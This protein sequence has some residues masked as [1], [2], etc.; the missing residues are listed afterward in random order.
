MQPSAEPM[1]RVLLASSSPSLL[2]RNQNL[3]KRRGVQILTVT[4]GREALAHHR[5]YPLDLILADMQ[6]G[7]MAGDLLCAEVRSRDS[8][9]VPVVLICHDQPGD[10]DRVTRSGAEAM[11]CRP[12]APLQLM[13]TV[14]RFLEMEMVRRKRIDLELEVSVLDKG[15]GTGFSFVSRDISS[16]GIRL[17]G[18]GG[19]ATGSSIACR[20]T[21][22]CTS[23]V[24]TDGLVVRRVETP[25]G[26]HQYG[27][28]FLDLPHS[29]RCQIESLVAASSS[30]G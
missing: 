3:L 5:D 21:L 16:S 25:G 4:T 2:E 7:D 20:F 29:S 1:K 8:R 14:G 30:A 28:L 18:E 12:V 9:S 6:L 26:R 27:V 15:A 19:L 24:E 22:P 13:E 10:R 11:L 23:R 17:E